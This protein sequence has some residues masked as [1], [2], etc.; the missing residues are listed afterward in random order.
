MKDDIDDD[1]HTYFHALYG[2]KLEKHWILVWVR[3]PLS[4]QS[5]CRPPPG[6]SLKSLPEPI[7]AISIR[8][9]SSVSISGERSMP[10]A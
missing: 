8:P 2:H 5:H 10:Q 6:Q 1:I 4:R 7:P 9:H 3:V